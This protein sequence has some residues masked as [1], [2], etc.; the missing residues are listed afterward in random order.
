MENT[1]TFCE[2]FII[3]CWKQAW[4][5][6]IEMKTFLAVSFLGHLGVSPYRSWLNQSLRY[7]RC[8]TLKLT[9]GSKRSRMCLMLQRASEWQ[10]YTPKSTECEF[11]RFDCFPSSNTT[12]GCLWL[13]KRH[14]HAFNS[15]KKLSAQL[16]R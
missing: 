2:S 5:M 3:P 7:Y 8:D 12:E 9:A 16:K 13:Q 10:Y 4:T 1:S 11:V 6:D 15:T 14:S